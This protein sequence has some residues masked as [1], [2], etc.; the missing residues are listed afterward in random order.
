MKRFVA[1]G[2]F[3]MLAACAGVVPRHAP[4]PPPPP[5]PIVKAAP[6]T[7]LPEDT[8]R[9]RIAL[10]VPLS[11]QNAAVG[12]SIADAAALALVD[13]G[14]KDLRITNYDTNLGAAAAAQ[15]A[16]ADGNT[17]FLGPLLAED[18]RAV[19]APA[20]AA[21]V[22]IISF[23]NDASVASDNVW[24]LGFSPTQSIDRVVRFG[25]SRGLTQFAGM[26][27]PGTYGHNVANTLIHTADAAGGRVVAMQSYSR[28]PK[29]VA[30]AVATLAKQ[31]YDA[32]LIADAGRSAVALV[33][34]LRKNGG[35]SARIIGPELWN[36]EPGLNAAPAMAGAWYASVDNA[37]FAQLSQRYS[38]RYGRTPYRLSSLGY[39]AVLLTTRI[40]RDWSIGAPFPVKA[41]ADEGGFS[42]VDGAFRF[43]DEHIA[44]RALAV[45]QLGPKGGIVVSPAP[46][47]F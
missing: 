38:A 12:R 22:P 8:S 21:G 1:F 16:I 20:A 47:E 25:R 10:L 3:L 18:V 31:K 30:T 34:L 27:P 40:A 26:I 24:L 44:E 4:A 15:K 11:G 43:R 14:G 45:H 39:D 28:T 9:H 35:A 46:K 19:T 42:G 36:A 13:T 29:S 33:P 23:S 17:V 5:A 41:L 32:V 7:G 6:Q 2:A 37:M